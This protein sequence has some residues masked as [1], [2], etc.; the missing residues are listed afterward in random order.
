[1]EESSEQAREPELGAT[2]SKVEMVSGVV[3][4]E[5]DK[6]EGETKGVEEVEKEKKMEEG[7]R[8]DVEPDRNKEVSDLQTTTEG[9]VIMW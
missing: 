3:S 2:G 1:M 9:Q 7:G 6:G 5:E 4:A 8:D